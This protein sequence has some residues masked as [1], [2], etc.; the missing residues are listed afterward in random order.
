MPSLATTGCHVMPDFVIRCGLRRAV[1]RHGPDP[2]A[3]DVL[4]IRAVDHA[5]PVGREA[6][7]LDFAIAWREQRRR[8]AASRHAV[9]V[10]PA[11]LLPWEDETIARAP[12]QLLIRH[13]SLEGA[14]VARVRLP[15][16]ARVTRLHVR[17]ADRPGL[18]RGASR[19]EQARPRRGRLTD[20]GDAAAIDGPRRPI[21]RDRVTDRRSAAREMPA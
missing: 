9:Q 8:A 6:D 12:E 17:H 3:I 21:R 19:R 18:V 15:H 16:L 4:V 1:H 20:P 10:Q 7:V 13:H 2:A 11:V 5:R 14:A